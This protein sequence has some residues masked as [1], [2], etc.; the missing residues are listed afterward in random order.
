MGLSHS[1]NVERIEFFELSSTLDAHDRVQSEDCHF[2]HESFGRT[3]R[4]Q[5]EKRRPLLSN[6][7]DSFVVMFGLS[8]FS[9]P[10]GWTVTGLATGK[11]PDEC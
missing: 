8:E 7:R 9:R 1:S 6:D 10:R 2:L 3:I 11:S 5:F 4:A